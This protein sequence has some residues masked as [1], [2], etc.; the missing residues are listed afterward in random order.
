MIF[1]LFAIPFIFL[2]L[3]KNQICQ[4]SLSAND[5]DPLQSF[6]WFDNI[7]SY[8]K[9]CLDSSNCLHQTFGKVSHLTKRSLAG[10]KPLKHLSLGFFTGY[11]SG[12]CLR[13][14]TKFVSFLFGGIYL[15]I[16]LLSYHGYIRVNYEKVKQDFDFIFDSNR[17]G[18]VDHSDMAY[19]I[20]K[21]H[22]KIGIF[23]I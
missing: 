13:K 16:Q 21:V 4:A 22:F 2:L 17:D 10:H 6:G 8:S 11:S 18:V 12:I 19:Y 5:D 15:S 23:R 1:S 14:A 3:G 7:L 9:K 20:S